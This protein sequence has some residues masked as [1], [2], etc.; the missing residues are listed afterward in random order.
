MF[1]FQS[2]L[3][4]SDD[5]KLASR[6]EAPVHHTLPADTVSGS[7]GIR[8]YLLKLPA[9]FIGFMY[10][11]NAVALKICLMTLVFI[12]AIYTKKYSGEFQLII[13]NHIGGIFYVLFGSLGFSVLFPRMRMIMP[14]LMATAATCILEFIQWF[15]FPVMVEL[16]ENKAFA[17]LFGNSFNP[18]DFVYYGAGAVTALLVLWFIREN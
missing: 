2:F 15:R 5:L 13:N 11:R 8:E 7:T 18:A 17:Y 16:T 3:P 1:R 10:R 4:Q 12:S 9:R 6:P 14:V